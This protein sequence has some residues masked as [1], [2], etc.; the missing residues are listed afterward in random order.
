[1]ATVAV[2]LRDMAVCERQPVAALLDEPGT[3]LEA[4]D[5]MLELA[6]ADLRLPFIA[7]ESLAALHRQV[8]FLRPF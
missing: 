2:V 1:M 5:E 6:R 4:L 7:H 3:L 8:E